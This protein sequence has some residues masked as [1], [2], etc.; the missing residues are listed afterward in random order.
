MIRAIFLKEW[1][2]TRLT[3]CLIG[4]GWL[5]LTVYVLLTIRNSM[6]VSGHV[7]TIATMLSRD[8]LFIEPLRYMPALAGVVL[9]FVQWM[10]EMTQKRLQLTLH[11]PLPY[12]FS[13]GSML[14]YG[15][16]VLAAIAGVNLLLLG[17]V[18]RLW[19]PAELIRTTLLTLL[20]AYVASLMAYLL[21]AWVVLEPTWSM[22]C[23]CIVM[24][25]GLLALFFLNAMP[26]TYMRLL[27]WLVLLTVLCAG[28]PLYSVYRFQLGKGL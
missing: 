2:K 22:R 20:P 10:P 12:P 14:G 25:I 15:V 9:A 23:L 13:V 17:Y 26:L 24:S 8:M 21:T 27:P 28:L 4:I 18:E 16:F 5:A 19:V 1:W 3:I 11:L 6:M 7:E